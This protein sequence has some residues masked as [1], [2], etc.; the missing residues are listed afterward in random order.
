MSESNNK[1]TKKEK[2]HLIYSIFNPSGNGKG[3][4]PE[5]ARKPRDFKNFFKF[6]G[7]N[8]TTI[9]T[10]NFLF[11]FGNFP[12]F[13]ALI[14]G[15][16]Y[17]DIVS[18]APSS[19]LFGP[20]YGAL[21]FTESS[22]V[23]SALFGAVCTQ[24]KMSRVTTITVVLYC[25]TLLLLLTFGPIRTGITCIVRN[26]V[27]GEPIFFW[28]DFKD[29]IKNNLRQCIIVGAID[30]LL[31]AAI[32]FDLLF[33]LANSQAVSF[34]LMLGA[35]IVI[36]FVYFIMRFY[37]YPIMITFDLSIMKI[38]K[39]SFILALAGMKRNLPGI[40]GVLVVVMLNWSVLLTYAPIGMLL[41]IVI[42][43]GTCIFIGIYTSYPKIK[44]VMIDPY[45]ES[46]SP[47][48]RPRKRT[49]TPG[50]KGN[51]GE[52]I[53][54]DEKVS[55]SKENHEIEKNGENQ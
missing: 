9:M 49:A 53:I 43:F 25:L 47:G 18:Y 36:A 51:G 4:T 27:R 39:N 35:S 17:F 33:F 16:G 30:L 38:F 46:D 21:G 15:A 10:L 2:K 8:I 31:S 29:A 48:A 50:A 44:E 42:T 1:S 19:P 24:T 3:L 5:E 23:K 12:V 55:G 41:P 6:F 40:L 54:A 52:N 34:G 7:R 14:A 13:F 20:V 11:I 37:I 26:I 28:S 45:Y 22:P 32:V